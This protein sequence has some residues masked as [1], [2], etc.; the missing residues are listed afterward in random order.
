V[1]TKAMK[2]MQARAIFVVIWM[3]LIALPAQAFSYFYS[4]YPPVLSQPIDI[5]PEGFIT[6][7][8]ANETF[9]YCKGIFY[10]K[11]MR[12]QKYAIVPPP[13]GAVVFDI[14]IGY[15]YLFIDGVAY[16]EYQGVYYQRV[17]EGYRVIFPP[18]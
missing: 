5:L 10:Q 8:V 17:L 14:P 18:V 13:I 4:P 3:A 1:E 16:Y 11:L 15:R 9:Y 12:D 7:N 2:R 6:I